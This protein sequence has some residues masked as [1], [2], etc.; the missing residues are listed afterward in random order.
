[1]PCIRVTVTQLHIAPVSSI[2]ELPHAVLLCHKWHHVTLVSL[3]CSTSKILLHILLP[4]YLLDHFAYSRSRSSSAPGRVIAS[5]A[6]RASR[7]VHSPNVRNAALRSWIFGF[8]AFLGLLRVSVRPRSKR[9][10]PSLFLTQNSALP[11]NYKAEIV[12][13]TPT[14]TTT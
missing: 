1:M 13:P 12:Q 6:A 4:T 10:C 5:F 7:G 14:T 3:S 8:A 9:P 2:L 11:T